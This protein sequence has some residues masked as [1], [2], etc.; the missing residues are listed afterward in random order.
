MATK[1][2]IGIDEVGRGPLA[3]PV[4]TA[5]VLMKKTAYQRLKR[6]KIFQAGKDSKKLTVTERLFYFQKIKELKERGK[7]NYAVSFCRHTTI[8]KIGIVKSVARAINSNL[9]KLNPQP[10]ATLILL[11]G[12]L[13]APPVFFHQKTI[14][15][16]DEREL[17]ISLASIAAKIT[18]DK[19]MI[20]LAEI[21]PSYDFAGNKG[22]GSKKHIAALK[23]HGP[24][25]IHRQSYIKHFIRL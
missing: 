18:R 17:I 8:D 25:E 19:K 6:L 1:Y 13:K 10:K 2:I 7:L 15:R 12:G 9:V 24:C 14:I 21:F 23:R 20:K 3:G 4:A 5:A 22:Y 11:D 16:G